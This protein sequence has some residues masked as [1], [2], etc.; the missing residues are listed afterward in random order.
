[1]NSNRKTA[2]TVG[3][4]IL[5]ATVAFMIGNA[6]IESVLSNPEYLNNVLSR[7]NKT[8]SRNVP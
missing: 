2:I 8:N 3:V 7:Q 6:L 1:M 4:F 5:A